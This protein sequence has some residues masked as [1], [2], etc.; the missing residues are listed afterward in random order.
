MHFDKYFKARFMRLLTMAL[1]LK[2]ALLVLA[3][4]LP[5]I[6]QLSFADLAKNLQCFQKYEP[7]I[8]RFVQ[9]LSDGYDITHL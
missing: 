2:A 7:V 8:L 9:S 6:D 3:S 4:F 5:P 1:F